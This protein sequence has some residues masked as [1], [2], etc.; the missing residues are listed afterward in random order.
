[1]TALELAQTLVELVELGLI[2]LIVRDD[3]ETVVAPVGGEQS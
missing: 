1:M 2:T 3:G